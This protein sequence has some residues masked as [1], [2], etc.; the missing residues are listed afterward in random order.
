MKPLF[1]IDGTA[2]IY[3]AF[4]AVRNLSYLGKPTNAIFGFAQMMF[5]VLRDF[6]P[7]R[8]SI[9]FDSKEKN[10]R[11]HMFPA[12][13]ANR[14]APPEGLIE[15]IP[16]I[17]E[18][19]DNFGIPVIEVAGVEADDVIG[20]LAFKEAMN[21]G[22]CV[23]ITG[24]KDLMQIVS[25]RIRLFDP[26]KDRPWTDRAGVVERFGVGPEKVTDILALAGD[27]SDNIP[28]VKG[29]GEKTAEKLVTEFGGIEEIYRD[30]S[31]VN[32]EK[33]REKLEN[34]R[35]NAFLSKR[36]ATI[37]LDVQLP[38]GTAELAVKE[39]AAEK[40]RDI[41]ARY[42]LK[43]LI[44]QLSSSEK[45]QAEAVNGFS[46]PAGIPE[47][48]IAVSKE[49]KLEALGRRDYRTVLDE[50]VLGELVNDITGAETIAVDTETTSL[51]P[52]KAGLVGLSIAVGGGRAYYIPLGHRLL[53]SPRQMKWETV[54]NIL[55]PVLA[56]KKI[57]AQNGKYDYEVLVRHGLKLNIN[58]DTMLAA[59]LLD[60]EGSH[61]LSYLSK[62]YLGYEM[63][64]YKELLPK[65]KSNIGFD[66]VPIEDA[67]KYSCED[68]DITLKLL[69]ILSGKLVKSGLDQLY[70]NVEMPLMTIL[71]GLEMAGVGVDIE[72]LAKLSKELGTS[73]E[74]AAA[75]IFR[76][77]GGE[78][79][80]SSPK[81]LGDILFNR[82][83]LRV[84]KR[85][86]NGP[87]TDSE[88]LEELAAE[89]DIA[90]KV[91][92]YRSLEKLRGTYIEA[93]PAMINPATGRIHCSFNQTGTSTGR[94]S[95]SKPNLQNIPIRT[96]LGR[97]IRE[98]FTA[99]EGC[100]LL[101]ADYSQIELRVL[102]H[103]SGDPTLIKA[104]KSGEDIH[105]RTASEL[106][107]VS[108]DSVS[109]EMRRAAKTINFGIVYGMSAFRLA[110]ELGI[111]RTEAQSYIDG[112]F[113]R[114]P[115]VKKFMESILEKSRSDGFTQT[116]FG[117]RRSVEGLSSRNVQIRQAAERV[118]INTPIQGTAADIM[119]MA[120][121]RVDKLTG[122][123]SRMLLQVHD[124]LLFET[125]EGSAEEF[126]KNVVD[127]MENA[128][129]LDV[130]LRVD[131]RTGRNWAEAH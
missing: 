10:F 96:P 34:S 86:K 70:K 63:L 93:L 97:M 110:R 20:T 94:L 32:N 56:G 36:L 62:K 129:R 83:G 59:Y 116:L 92:A 126:R 38:S 42:E 49:V 4:Y 80:I 99:P 87:S 118:A 40:L 23:V 6:S 127:A 114:I 44:Q 125:C 29:V 28:G 52:M 82:L 79:N 119:K 112:Y 55:T 3:R 35:E 27:Q 98:A 89:N 109:S 54:K 75:E 120:M 53:D 9:V 90:S 117:R 100:L 76:L 39:P 30:L 48:E 5:K 33:L 46:P 77:A 37:V 69:P 2:Y 51:E 41:F 12:Y 64:E 31:K 104:F 60:P 121:I 103:M 13:K 47:K 58:D 107:G 19:A 131:A 65:S 122:N 130:P 123:G 21:G 11:H 66:E 7:E 8:A 102:A 88:V 106:F 22:E 15:Q 113:A 74:M 73:M 124:E 78:F 43:S 24:D 115:G 84:I 18:M 71:A 101:S 25:D 85:S 17:R 57:C 68:A 45:K 14:S 111:K 67:T 81:Q 95:S 16:A 105:S 50:T 1:I 26:M 72:A 108:P 128:A 91:L 61:A